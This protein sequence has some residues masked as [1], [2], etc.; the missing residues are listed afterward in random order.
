[1]VTKINLISNGVYGISIIFCFPLIL[2]ILTSIV[3]IFLYPFEKLNNIKYIN[4]AKS[5]FLRRPDLIKIGI[6]GSF[7][8][9]SVKNILYK[10]LSIKYRVIATEG[11]YN[12][13]L[14]IARTI[15]KMD[16]Y[17]EVFIAEM[18]AR[19]IGDIKKLVDIVKPCYGILTGVTTQHLETFKSLDKIYHEKFSLLNHLPDCGLGVANSTGYDVLL[20]P[21]LSDNVSV[22]G[23]EN[24]EAYAK[25]IITSS[26]GVS[27]TLVLCG[28]EYHTYTKLLGEH[29]IQNI[30]SASY[31]AY[32]LK[33][34]AQ[35]IISV[36]EDLQPI[37]HRL[38]IVRN[39]GLTI[40]DDT[41][42]ANPVGV[43][44][45]LK[46]LNR[47]EGRKVVI[48]PGMVELGALE[49][50]EN[51]KLGIKLAEVAN[52]VI[53]LG[54]ERIMPIQKGLADNL[55]DSANV[56]VFRNLFEAET[57]FSKLLK[58]GDVVLFLNDLPDS[59]NE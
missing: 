22:I 36:I 47:F 8:K 44:E 39:C 11:N 2:P 51:Y 41:Y 28:N 58:D 23:G 49:Y 18:G 4:Q 52:L 29:N 25:N 54:R 31:L 43:V 30:V 50:D 55:Y 24:S 12:T 17:T 27:F 40:I 34:P 59:Y 9:T 42:N 5:V 33:V 1:M 56:R 20:A 32:K 10:M 15:S 3:N 21:K 38:Q 14:G 7:G 13:P 37:P 26:N 46:V 35:N 45:A 19:H 57:Q 16:E 48:T 6:T 53:L